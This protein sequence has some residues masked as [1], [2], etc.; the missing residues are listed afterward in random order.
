MEVMGFE[1]VPTVIDWAT[2]IG[3]GVGLPA[4]ILYLLT[5]RRKANNENRLAEK[6][7]KASVSKADSGALEAHVLAVEAAFRAERDSKDRV[8]ASLRAEV[9]EVEE[10][11]DDR[12]AE[13]TRALAAKDD[14]IAELR[15]QVAT[16]AADLAH[17]R[18]QLSREA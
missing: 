13:M 15:D 10:R 18:Q 4:I 9:R 6:T 1:W 16:L 14:T 3:G 5:Q 17:L 12:V 11:C 7:E 2:K 8:I